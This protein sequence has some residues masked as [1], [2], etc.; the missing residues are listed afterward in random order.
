MEKLTVEES[1]GDVVINTNAQEPAVDEYGW[2]GE[3][4]LSSI[5]PC[6]SFSWFLVKLFS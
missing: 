2:W 6:P 3:L 5:I 4:T 1:N